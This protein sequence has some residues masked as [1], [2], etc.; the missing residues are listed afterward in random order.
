METN[1][2]KRLVSKLKWF[3]Y[4]L[5]KIKVP[6]IGYTK[7]KL[8]ELTDTSVQVKIKLRWR[9]RNHLNSMYFGALSV[10]ADVTAG[11]HAFYFAKKLNKKVSF[12]FKGMDAQFIKRAETDIV[13]TTDEGKLIKDAIEESIKTG[14]RINQPIKVVATDKQGETVAVFTM[15]CSMRCS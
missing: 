6:M 15:V 2:N 1:D 13:F 5:G 3:L 7:P 11:I 4:L 12:A 10:G 8:L 14:N 9:T